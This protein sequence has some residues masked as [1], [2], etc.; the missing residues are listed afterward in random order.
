MGAPSVE[1]FCRRLLAT[2]D[3]LDFI[4]NNACQTVRRPPD[5]YAHMMAGETARHSREANRVA[6]G[7]PGGVQDFVNPGD[8]DFL[9]AISAALYATM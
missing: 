6:V 5:F 8:F 1:T 4:I 7:R 9:I 2:R 3:R